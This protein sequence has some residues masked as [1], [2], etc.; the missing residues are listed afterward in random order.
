VPSKRIDAPAISL[1]VYDVVGA[2]GDTAGFICHAGLAE[3][4]GSHDA[5][6]IAVLDMGPPLH[7]SHSAGQICASCVGSAE[8]TD[9]EVRKITN[10]VD[11]H[12]GEHQTF[13]QLTSRQLLRLAPQMYCIFPHAEPFYEDDQRY[14]RMRF[15]C[16]GFVFEAY[17]TAGIRLLDVSALPATQMEDIKRGYPSQTR[18]MESGKVSPESLGLEGNGPWPVL[19]CGYLFHALSREPDV[20][21]QLPYAPTAED[22]RFTGGQASTPSG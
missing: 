2:D 21:R 4:A 13:L 7:T 15:S 18:L 5:Q 22:Q 1:S 9:D 3:S 14:A 8:L 20:I 10:F 19:F 17:R 12:A 16:A 6:A 11:R